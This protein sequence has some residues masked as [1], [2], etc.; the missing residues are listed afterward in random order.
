MRDSYVVGD[1]RILVTSDRLSAFDRV[2]TTI[3]FKGQIL[4][5]MASFWFNTTKHIIPNHIISEPHPNVFIARQVDIV[6]VEVVVRGYLAGSSYRDYQAGRAVSGITLPRCLRKS[7]RFPQP[8]LTPSTKAE[9]G[10]HDE[11]ISSEEV[12]RRGIVS[13]ETWRG[14]SDKAR[15]L[16]QCGTIE[17]R[18]R[19]LILVDTKYEFGLVTD[20][21][22]GTKSLILADEIHTPDSSRYWVAESYEERFS[23]GEDPEML[24][25]E[26][27]RRWLI[28]EGYMGEG[29]APIFTDEFRVDI[30]LRYMEVCEQITGS[31]F[32]SKVGSPAE[33]II[34]AVTSA[35][36]K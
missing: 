9:K 17:A 12:V 31:P 4:N 28:A 7:E 30:A 1:K 8:L 36:R 34:G 5:R 6:P 25:K 35:L 26:F 3:P 19:G 29:S 16:F 24:D 18:K 22:I 13:A 14:I 23:K 27:V 11:P 33:E 15:Q 21:K 2:L 20:P 32:E 10:T